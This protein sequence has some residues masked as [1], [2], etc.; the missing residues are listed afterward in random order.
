MSKWRSRF[1]QR[2]FTPAERAYCQQYQNPARHFAVRF[3][4]KE[5][6]LKM[7]ADNLEQ[8]NWQELEI[9]NDKSGK[10]EVNLTGKAARLQKKKKIKQIHVSLTHEKE[11]AL[12][13]VIG[14]G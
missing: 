2:V 9:I 7:L 14:E 11:Y 13:Q 5:A 1:L 8:L 4:A 12:A 6:L 3:A 10:P